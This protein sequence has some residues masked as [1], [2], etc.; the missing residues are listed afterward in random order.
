LLIS[1][2]AAKQLIAFSETLCPD[3][4]ATIPS[5]ATEMTECWLLIAVGNKKGQA[6]FRTWP[7]ISYHLPPP[8]C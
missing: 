1:I 7:A 2:S 6:L 4:V 8:Y 3:F 5:L